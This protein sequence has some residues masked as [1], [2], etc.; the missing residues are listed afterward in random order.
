MNAPLRPPGE[1]TWA[2]R[3]TPAAANDPTAAEGNPI[4]GLIVG[5]RMM[6]DACVAILLGVW[7]AVWMLG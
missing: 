4:R 1:L 7:L 2:D 3:P 6:F 5:L